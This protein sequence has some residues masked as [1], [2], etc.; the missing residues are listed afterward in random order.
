MLATDVIGVFGANSFIGRNIVRNMVRE[1]V[2]VIAYGRRFGE[3]FQSFVGESV[4]TRVVDINDD[5]ETHASLHGLTHVIQLINN[6][7]PAVGN[8]KVVSD[9]HYNVISHVRFIE[10][11]IASKIKN[12]VFISSG[13][14]VYGVPQSLPIKEDHPTNPLNSYGLSKRVVEK[15][16]TMLC[17][18][19]E[20]GY[21]ILRVA[22]PFGPGQSAYKGQGLIPTI[23]QRQKSGLPVTILGDG[24]SQRDYLYIDDVVSAVTAAVTRQPL[25]DVVNIGSGKGRTVIEIIETIESLMD[26]PIAREFAEARPTDTPFNILD[27]TKAAGSLGWS[28]TTDFVEGMRETI[29]AYSEV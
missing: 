23:L 14:T 4:E 6:S 10:S 24:G 27:I 2:P 11:C 8:N 19:T 1:G 5:L 9:L 7:N 12:L 26:I 28:P 17:R 18:G 25:C 16:L 13:G 15:Y 29:K 22:N 21:T 3:D 20:L